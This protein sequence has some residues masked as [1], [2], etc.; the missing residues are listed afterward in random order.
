MS[1]SATLQARHLVNL[2]QNHPLP[3]LAKWAL[4]FAV[5]LT[6][7]DRRYR[8]RRALARLDAVRLK[9]IGIT[10]EAARHEASK[11]FWRH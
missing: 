11:K 2:S 5:K 6:T 10:P 4:A 3:V 9:D 8:T 7:W 1:H